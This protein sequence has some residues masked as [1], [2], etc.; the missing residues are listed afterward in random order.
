MTATLFLFVA[1]LGITGPDDGDDDATRE[2]AV[3]DT[4]MVSVIQRADVPA[5]APGLLVSLTAREGVQ[6]EEGAQLAQVDDSQAEAVVTL[7]K[8]EAA[9]AEAEVRNDINVRYAKAAEQVADADY[10][11]VVEANKKVPGAIQATELRLKYLEWQRAALQIEQAQF[12]VTLAKKTL[13]ARTAELT[14]AEIDVA[15]RKVTAPFGG[16]IV[17]LHK[18]P[19][20]WAN[21]GEPILHLVRLDKLRVEGFVDAAK[22]GP[23]DVD[24]KPVLVEVRLERDRTASFEG[25]IVFVDPFVQQPGG[26][27]KVWAEVENRRENGH[28]VLRPGHKVK[29]KITT[30]AETQPAGDK[31]AP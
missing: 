26:T 8:A 4:C 18:Q 17:E 14:A 12:D 9:R 7:K 19:G 11:Q 10:Q 16:V 29:M 28:F 25:R 27:Y 2:P 13:E 5:Q 20:E 6:V 22:L 24:G 21:A 3:L 31:T 15:R 30:D 23:A 1:L